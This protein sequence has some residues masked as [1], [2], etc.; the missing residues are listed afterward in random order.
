MNGNK[1]MTRDTCEMAYEMVN[2]N[3]ML[4]KIVFTQAQNIINLSDKLEKY[5]P[6]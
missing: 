4:R 3:L 5:E 2:D 1:S 6:K